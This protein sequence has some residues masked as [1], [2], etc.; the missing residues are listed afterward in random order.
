MAVAR[1]PKSVEEF[2][3]TGGSVPQSVTPVAPKQEEKGPEKEKE[4]EK[5]LKLRLPASLL[6]RVDEAVASRRP[7]PSRHQWIL[8]AIY[9]KLDREQG[10]N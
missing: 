7:A 9:E 1:K 5:G 4:E 2:I 6:Q 8:E 10:E 3:E